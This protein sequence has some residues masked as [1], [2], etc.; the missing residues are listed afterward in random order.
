M[1]TQ[2]DLGKI[3]RNFENQ[4]VALSPDYKKVV[5]SGESL[6]EVESKLKPDEVRKVVFHKVPPLD[7]VF[8]PTTL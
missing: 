4:W 1:N 7:S 5:A 6:N 8:I 3:L 2:R